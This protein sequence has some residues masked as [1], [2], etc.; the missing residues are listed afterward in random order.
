[1]VNDWLLVLWFEAIG[2]WAFS[3]AWLVKGQ[4]DRSLLGIVMG[5]KRLSPESQDNAD[6]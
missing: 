5:T 3:I 6:A 2:I 1:M 4:V